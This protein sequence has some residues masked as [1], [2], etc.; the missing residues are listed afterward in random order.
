MNGLVR[1]ARARAEQNNI[2]GK[3]SGET[4]SGLYLVDV[5]IVPFYGAGQ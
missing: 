1:T 5:K 2:K 4:E 3:E